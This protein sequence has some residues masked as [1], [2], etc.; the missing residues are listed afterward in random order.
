MVDGTTK[1]FYRKNSPRLNEE[2]LNYL[3]NDYEP[4]QNTI[5]AGKTTFLTYHSEY[6]QDGKLFR[7]HSN[8]NKEGPWNDWVMIRWERDGNYKQDKNELKNAMS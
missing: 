8:F 2:I 1:V 4:I 5:K 6:K 3:L 7:G